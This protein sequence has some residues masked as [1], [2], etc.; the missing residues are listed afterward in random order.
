MDISYVNGTNKFNYRVC[1]I[2]IDDNKILAMHDER[3]PYYYLPGGRVT[4]GETAEQAVIREVYEEL[5]IKASIIRPLWLNQAFF[6]E[7]VDNLNYHEICIY[8]L[9]DISNTD[10]LN[11]GKKFITREGNYTHSFEWLAFE[12]LKDEYF[13]PIFLKKE[14]YNLPK[15]FTIRIENE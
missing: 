1:A 6:T 8:F 5:N 12:K 2:I 9:M 3:S 14:I 11:K 7:D 15:E 4:I 13:Y 10:I